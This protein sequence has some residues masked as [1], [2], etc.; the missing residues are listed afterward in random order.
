MA[1]FDEATL[2]FVDWDK[3]FANCKSDKACLR[4][5]AAQWRECATW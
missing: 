5:V 4:A 1:D 2:C 3:L